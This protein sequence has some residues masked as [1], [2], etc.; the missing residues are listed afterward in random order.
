MVEE[1]SPDVVFLDLHMPGMNGWELARRL[2]NRA[3]PP[4]LVAITGADREAD[5]QRS[6]EVGIH[7]HLVKP[8]DPEILR[9]MLERFERVVSKC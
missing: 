8:A 6:K 5:H 7:L 9:R 3:K 4:L 1:V 2:R